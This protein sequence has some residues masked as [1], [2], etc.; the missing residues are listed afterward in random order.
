MQIENELLHSRVTTLS[1]TVQRDCNQREAIASKLMEVRPNTSAC[2]SGTFIKTRQAGSTRRP[3]AL[4]PVVLPEV[5]A[6]QAS[7]KSLENRAKQLG[8]VSKPIYLSSCTV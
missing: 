8:Q 5:A 7:S 1:K 6:S 3:T 4:L 2:T